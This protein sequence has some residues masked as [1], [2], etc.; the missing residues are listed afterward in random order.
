MTREFR[1]RL[2]RLILLCCG[3][4]WGVSLLGVFA[5]WDTATRALQGLGAGLV[6]YDPRLDYWLRMVAGAFGLLGIGYFL[7]ALKPSD[8]RAVLPWAGWLMVLEGIV[9][10]CHGVRLG[11]PP[12][13]FY[14]DIAA[15]FAGGGGILVLRRAAKPETEPPV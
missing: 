2:L 14:A 1:F 13:P 10:A 15:C 9:L 11:L 6:A 5:S 3:L 4:T 8:Y 12:F 7:L